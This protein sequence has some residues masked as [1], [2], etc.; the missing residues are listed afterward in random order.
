MTPRGW[1]GNQKSKLVDLEKRGVKE[2]NFLLFD[3]SL[4]QG[5]HVRGYTGC[6]SMACLY[7]LL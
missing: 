2:Y 5:P 1:G 3:F 6:V 7:V 4:A